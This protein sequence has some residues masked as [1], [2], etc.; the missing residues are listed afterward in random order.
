MSKTLAAFLVAIT[1]AG[2]MASPVSAQPYGYH[3]GRHWHGH[4]WRN[5]HR[6]CGWHHGRCWRR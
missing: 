3:H 6:H 5:W 4:H 2:G 1:L